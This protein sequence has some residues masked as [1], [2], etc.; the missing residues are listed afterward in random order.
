MKKSF[1]L[2]LAV[3]SVCFLL[4]AAARADI[5]LSAAE[6]AQIVRTVIS[7]KGNVD[8][9]T[10]ADQTRNGVLDETDIRVALNRCVG[11]IPDYVAFVDH[12]TTGLCDERLFSVFSYTGTERQGH[13]YRSDSVCL[14]VTSVQEK[15]LAYYVA[16]IYVQDLE[17]FSTKLTDGGANGKYRYV[18]EV[19]LSTRALLC[20][21]GDYYKARPYGPI[22]RNGEWIRENMSRTR[23]VCIMDRNGVITTYGPKELTIDDILEIDPWQYWIFGPKLL[24]GEGQPMTKFN[25]RLTAANPRTAIGYYEPGH[26]CLVVVDGRQGDYSH[27]ITMKDLSQ[28]FYDLGCTAAYNLDGGESSAMADRNG[29]INIPYRN[30]RILSDFII[31]TDP[32][33]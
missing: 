26:Y 15:R 29:L 16:D 32:S 28:L 14:T 19:A 17:A 5:D 3:L 23:D 21:N 18:E 12:I 22:L 10:L 7:G 31:I 8:E 30:G 9:K 2:L 27:G 33:A 25:S 1:L 4:P 20:V 11:L 13:N 6:A 24:D